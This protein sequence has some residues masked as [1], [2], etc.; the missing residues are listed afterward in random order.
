MI[1]LTEKNLGIVIQ[2]VLQNMEDE[3]GR[4]EFDKEAGVEQAVSKVCEW[5]EGDK[6]VRK[7]LEK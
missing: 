1:P 7:L 5:V 6:S 2:I 3:N 4:G